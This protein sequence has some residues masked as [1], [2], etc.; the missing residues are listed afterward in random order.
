MADI[1]MPSETMIT[2]DGQNTF[3]ISSAP[4]K[5]TAMGS[6]GIGTALERHNNGAN[7]AFVDGHAKWMTR[8]AIDAAMIPGQ[9]S[10]FMNVVMQP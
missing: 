5:A 9:Y 8:G 6:G 1:D 2:M 7:V 10:V 3:L 4:S